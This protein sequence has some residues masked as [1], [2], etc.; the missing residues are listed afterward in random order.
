MNPMARRKSRR[1]WYTDSGVMA[2]SGKCH[3][4]RTI[5]LAM[6]EIMAAVRHSAL[7]FSEAPEPGVQNSPA[8]L[9]PG[10]GLTPGIGFETRIQQEHH[11]DETL[12]DFRH[13]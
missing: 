7:F 2:L 10:F 3:G 1:R 8:L 13:W 11:L 12:L 6:G 4:G 5:T 9:L